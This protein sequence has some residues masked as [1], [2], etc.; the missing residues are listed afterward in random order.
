MPP[1][2][3]A[4]EPEPEPEPEIESGHELESDRVEEAEEKSE[5]KNGEGGLS[6]NLRRVL[7]IQVRDT[8]C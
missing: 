1:K 8:C 5:A 2:K 3:K 4:H 6:E 7:F